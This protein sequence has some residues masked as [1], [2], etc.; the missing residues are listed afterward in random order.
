MN[1]C[2]LC[3]F[4]NKSSVLIVSFPLFRTHH[5]FSLICLLST[6]CLSACR[7][8]VVPFQKL[9]TLIPGININV[10]NNRNKTTQL[11]FIIDRSN[12]SAMGL[13]L[14]RM[15]SG[16]RDPGCQLVTPAIG[17]PLKLHT[18][19]Y[20]IQGDTTWT[21]VFITS[22]GTGFQNLLSSSSI[23]SFA[24]QVQQDQMIVRPA[25]AGRDH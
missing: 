13:V 16:S 20:E 22:N 24:A 25:C 9:H 19:L 3:P 5:H 17:S 10:K 18:K 11:K 1:K 2:L 14:Y 23:R 21:G 6:C 4:L 7:Q 8:Q 12:S 15:L